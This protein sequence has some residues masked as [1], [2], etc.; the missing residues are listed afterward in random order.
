MGRITVKGP[1]ISERLD[2]TDASLLASFGWGEFADFSKKFILG[3]TPQD[4]KWFR[5]SAAGEAAIQ[6]IFDVW[7]V[8]RK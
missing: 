4:G 2:I 1:G 8:P 6:R 5:V 3:G 7:G